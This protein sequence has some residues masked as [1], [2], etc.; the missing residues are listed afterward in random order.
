V[1]GNQRLGRLEN[2]SDGYT[3]SGGTMRCVVFKQRM[4]LPDPWI[5][6]IPGSANIDFTVAAYTDTL[7]KGA[8]ECSIAGHRECIG[9]WRWC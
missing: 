5:A 1:K 3:A 8:G 9:H 6:W 4:H 7:R 2:G